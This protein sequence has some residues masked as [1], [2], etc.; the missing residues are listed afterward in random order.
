MIH[1]EN[2]QDQ[3]HWKSFEGALITRVK[4][5]KDYD[6][7]KSENEDA[8]RH[9]AQLCEEYE[10]GS[11]KMK[12]EM[13]SIVQQRDAENETMKDTIHTKN[14]II[15]Q[16]RQE[17]KDLHSKI[18]QMRMDEAEKDSHTQKEITGSTSELRKLQNELDSLRQ[19]H[20]VEVERL[21][22]KVRC[23]SSTTSIS[24]QWISSCD[25]LTTFNSHSLFLFLQCSTS[26]VFVFVV[27]LGVNSMNRR[28]LISQAM[29]WEVLK[30]K[31]SKETS[32]NKR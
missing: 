12:E 5:V 19:S 25:C 29:V 17:I 13:K 18:T 31:F 14:V 11:E 32:C 30:F 2:E 8:K 27:V 20:S 7:M 9:I 26:S 24:S 16:S 28:C 22:I 15:E 21:R 1:Q 3:H 6:R 23:Q 4:H 10:Q